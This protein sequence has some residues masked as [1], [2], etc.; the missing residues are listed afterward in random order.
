MEAI[1][2]SIPAAMAVRRV[3]NKGGRPSLNL[4]GDELK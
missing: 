3:K 1:K 4:V 2:E